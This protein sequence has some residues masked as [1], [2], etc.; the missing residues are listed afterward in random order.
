M[1]ECKPTIC[2]SCGQP[3]VRDTGPMI[4]VCTEYLR[5]PP[6]PPSFIERNGLLIPNTFEDAV[7]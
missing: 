1:T 2:Q 5:K 4:C 7:G 3:Y 6:S